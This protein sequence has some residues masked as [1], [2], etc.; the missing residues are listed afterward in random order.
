M[1]DGQF[2]RIKNDFSR[3]EA[4]AK[5]AAIREIHYVETLRWK[6]ALVIFFIGFFLGFAVS[7]FAHASGMTANANYNPANVTIT[8]GTIG[9]TSVAGV[10]AA[11]AASPYNPTSVAIT[12]GTIDNANIG[13]ITP[14]SGVFSS[15][16][17][18]TYFDLP[19][20]GSSNP[21]L[22]LSYGIFSESGTGLGVYSA[23][24][25]ID[26]WVGSTP[27]DILQ[28]TANSLS[29]NKKLLFSSTAPTIS[30][31][32]G[33]GAS[34]IVANG[35]AAFEIN[36]GTGGDTVGSITMPAAPH[37]WVCNALANSANALTQSMYM[38]GL[39]STNVTINN[40][41]TA[42]GILVAWSSGDYIN[43]RCIPL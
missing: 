6:K 27:V 30:A 19:G 17:S 9:G 31:G 26:F 22:N 8:G 14:A 38:S 10:A 21:P 23:A 13:S 16:A 25:G 28:L 5:Q 1:A 40:F 32:F 2:G 36:V 35:T 15:A 29:L 12:G 7:N 3:A 41:T 43:V 37:Y 33:P 42:S 18:N 4:Y 20:A 34:V 11:G 24:V 39:T